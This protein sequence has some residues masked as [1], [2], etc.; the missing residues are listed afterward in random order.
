MATPNE[1][2]VELKGEPVKD[3]QV[4]LRSLGEDFMISSAVRSRPEA[5]PGL[6]IDVQAEW[7]LLTLE[8]LLDFVVRIRGY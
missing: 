4:G 3:A 1:L 7:E 5:G 2:K 8:D 6:E